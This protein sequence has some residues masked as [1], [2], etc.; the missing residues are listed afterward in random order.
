MQSNKLPDRI[1]RLYPN[2]SV[3]R[4][5]DPGLSMPSRVIIATFCSL[6]AV[7]VLLG[8]FGSIQGQDYQ[9][10]HNRPG[11]TLFLAMVFASFVLGAIT[12][13]RSRIQVTSSRIFAGDILLLLLWTVAPDWHGGGWM[14]L[15]IIGPICLYFMLRGPITVALS[16]WTLV[17]AFIIGKGIALVWKRSYFG[18]LL[19]EV[20]KV[21]AGKLGMPIT[22]I[23]V[24]LIAVLLAIR[25]FEF[26]F[27]PYM[28]FGL[29]L[30]L[31]IPAGILYVIVAIRMQGRDWADVVIGAI[32]SMLFLI[33]MY[34]IAERVKWN[35]LHPH[36]HTIP[37][38]QQPLPPPA[39]NSV[40]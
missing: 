22:I 31:A 16:R 23:G 19:F 9:E 10:N 32:L 12:C 36:L 33:V 39:G 17:A 1:F 20:L 38:M 14:P 6:C 13:F 34:P 8:I 15:L 40:R 29:A 24:P 7:I 26:A 3:A 11:D 2:P 18:P 28:V 25:F 37:T 27:I 35:H 21:T 4:V 5:P 30:A